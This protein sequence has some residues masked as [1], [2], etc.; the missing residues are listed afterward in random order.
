[1]QLTSPENQRR[2][3]RAP[4]SRCASRLLIAALVVGLGPVS[5][6]SQALAGGGPENVLLLVNANSDSSKTIA[7]HFIALR[8][9][10]AANV[11]YVDWKGGLE[12]CNIVNFREAVLRPAINAIDNRRLGTQIDYIIYSSDFPWR[13]ELKPLFP[14]E[15]FVPEFP[16][17]GSLTGVTYLAPFILGDKPSPAIVMPSVNWYVPKFSNENLVNCKQLGDVPSRGFRSRYLWDRNGDKTQTAK[18]GQRYLLSTCL[19]VTQG[20]GNTVAEVISYLTRSAAA[21]G[22]QPNGTIYYM[23]NGN[24]RSTVRQACFGEAAAAIER[25]G[26]NAKVQSGTIP[27][28]AKDVLGIMAGID[29]IDIASAGNVLLPGAICEHLTSAGGILSANGYQTP[30]TDFLRQGAA[31]ASGTVIEPLA[32]QAKFPLPSLHLHYVRGCSLAE[33]FYQSVS[34][35]YQLLI[36]GDPLC[37]PWAVRP[38]IAVGGLEAGQKVKGSVILT[39]T[40]TAAA[41]QDVSV[42]DLYIN[43]RIFARAPTGHSIALDTTKLADGHHELRVVGAHVDAIETQGR[44]IVPF[45]VNNGRPALEFDVSPKGDVTA[46]TSLRVALRQAGAKAIVIRQNSRVVGRVDGEAGEVTIDARALGRGPTTL[47]ATSEGP[48]PARSPLVTLR[49][50]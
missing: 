16:P 45:V 50:R 23:R 24:V 2:F 19:G 17:T 44:A 41:G 3:A 47:Q 32:L 7:N 33:S 12:T 5:P 22:T 49:V 28:G 43:G 4:G 14:D 40:A 1:L 25:L 35:P 36:V 11:V 31:G 39:P 26:V 10:P 21:D 30:L 27:K 20:R 42:L 37:Q 46:Q 15:K 34:G 18:E 6:A 38:K 9:I 48:A 29:T 8:Q 13:V